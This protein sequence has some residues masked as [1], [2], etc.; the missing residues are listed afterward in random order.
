MSFNTKPL[1]G[2]L[3]LTAIMS[4]VVLMLPQLSQAQP[5]LQV[6]VGDTTASPGEQNTVISVYM[7]NWQDTVAGF[8]L[9]IQLDRPDIMEFQ[10][11]T[12]TVVDTT[13]WK[14]LEWDGSTCIDSVLSNWQDYDF[15]HV[16]THE[17][18]VG[19]FDTTGTLCSGWAMVDARSLSGTG[20]DLNVAGLA[21]SQSDTL[22]RGIA[23]QQ[24]GL[25]VKLLADVYNIPDSLTDRL[26][27]LYIVR[28]FHFSFSRPDGSSIGIAY[29]TV[30]DTTCWVCTAWAGDVCTNWEKVPVPPP[31][32]C[33]SLEIDTVEVPYIDTTVVF[34]IDGT[35]EVEA[36]YVCGDVDGSGAVNVADLTYMVNFLFKGGPEPQPMEAGDVDCQPGV[37]VADL[38]YMVNFLFKG[39]PEPCGC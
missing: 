38:T 32:G 15:I 35:L 6:R 39:G 2:A 24:G 27:N 37:N 31:E 18:T 25:L 13:Y 23:P 16:E 36:G 11:D 29:D 4:V 14:C 5:V 12:Q 21:F 9:Y 8:N 26:V 17:V 33:D 19:N 20:Y 3:I 28:D 10:T 22:N 34:L 30:P 1:R 7:S